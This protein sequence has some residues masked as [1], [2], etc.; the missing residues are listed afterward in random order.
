S[1]RLRHLNLRHDDG[2]VLLLARHLYGVAGVRRKFGELLIRDRPDFLAVIGHQHELIARLYT[3]KRA[4]ALID[5]PAVIAAAT[6]AAHSAGPRLCGAGAEALTDPADP[7]DCQT[8]R[9]QSFHVAPREMAESLLTTAGACRCC[10]AWGRI[11][12]E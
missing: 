11:R 2:A 12:P 5:F 3:A 7:G 6:V 9:N 10:C 1:L 4:F 8:H